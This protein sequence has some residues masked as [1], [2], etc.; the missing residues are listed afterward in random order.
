MKGNHNQLGSFQS[1]KSILKTKLIATNTSIY[2]S[3]RI[4]KNT[5][6]DSFVIIGYPI[7]VKTINIWSNKDQSRLEYQFDQLSTGSIIGE[8][9]HIRPFTIIYENSTIKNQVET[10]TNVVVRENCYLGESSIIGSGSILD[11]GVTIGKNARIQSN[12]FI[13]PKITLGNNVFLGPG[14]KFANDTYPVSR[15]LVSTIVGDDVVI[16]IGSIIMSGITIGEK[17]VVAAG[18]IVTK[19][20]KENEVVRGEGNKVLADYR[21][22]IDYTTYFKLYPIPDDTYTLYLRYYVYPVTLVNDT[23]ISELKYKDHII[24]E[25]GSWK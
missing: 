25:T 17:S 7:R 9:C 16:G 21:F 18:S 11:S 2:G 23:D 6:I 20:V 13:P 22:Y 15:K 8:G 4:G 3:S 12:T 14:V 19:D 10:G 5:I 24:V 1:S